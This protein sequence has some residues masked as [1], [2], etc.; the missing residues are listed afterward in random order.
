[1]NFNLFLWIREG[2]KQSV[3]LGVSDAI[4]AIGTQ[5]GRHQPAAAGV[6]EAGRRGLDAQ[7]SRRR[8]PAKTLGSL[9]EGVGESCCSRSVG[10][11]GRPKGN[12]TLHRTRLVL[13]RS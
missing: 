6:H 3:L 11:C 10:D 4:E 2:V 8:R 1:M 13:A 5:L 9:A 7:V 12:R